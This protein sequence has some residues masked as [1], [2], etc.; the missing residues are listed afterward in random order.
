MHIFVSIL[1]MYDFFCDFL[2]LRNMFFSFLNIGPNLGSYVPK[3]PLILSAACFSFDNS[4]CSGL[5][6]FYYDFLGIFRSEYFY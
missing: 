4:P 1:Y 3:V 2:K 5:L 6:F